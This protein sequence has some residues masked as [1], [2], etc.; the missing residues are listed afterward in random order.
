MTKEEFMKLVKSM[1]TAQKNYFKSPAN[2]L[3]KSAALQRSKTL[4]KEV[5]AA[6]DEED[7]DAAAQLQ[8]SLF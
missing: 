2:T 7:K 5:D 1:Q 4:E 8:P 3:E 6:I